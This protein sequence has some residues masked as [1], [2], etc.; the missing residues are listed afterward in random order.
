MNTE[1]NNFILTELLNKLKLI[2]FEINEIGDFKLKHLG[3]RIQFEFVEVPEEIS[4]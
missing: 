2:Q 3:Q 1:K 4:K